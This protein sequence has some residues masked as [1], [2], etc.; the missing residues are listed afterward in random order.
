MIHT[1]GLCV[2]LQRHLD[3]L[4]DMQDVD[5]Y[6]RRQ[7]QIQAVRRTAR[8]AEQRVHGRAVFQLAVGP[9]MPGREE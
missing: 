6:L 8:I 1:L 9:E 4:E 7:Y 5:D 2:T 3:E